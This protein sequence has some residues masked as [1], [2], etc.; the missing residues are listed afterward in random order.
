MR[1]DDCL[2]CKNVKK[3]AHTVHAWQW[4]YTLGMRKSDCACRM[5]VNDCAYCVWLSGNLGG[6]TDEGEVHFML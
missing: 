3:N 4:L 6:R 5:V 2:H 1:G